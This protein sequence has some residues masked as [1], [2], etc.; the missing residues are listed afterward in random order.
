MPLIFWI[1]TVAMTI[2]ALLFVL[3]PVTSTGSRG[4][5]A[6]LAIAV[7]VTA[8]GLY[9][10]LGSPTLAGTLPNSEQ[11]AAV[12]GPRAATSQPVGSV[13]SLVGGLEER[14]AQNPDDGKGWL[15]LAQSYRHLQR[16]DDALNAY[17]HA[18]RL[19]QFDE[20]LDAMSNG[21]SESA[22]EA[23][24]AAGIS[25]TIS[26]SDEAA[27]RVQPGDRLFIFARASG[28]S[29]A[30]A[31]VVQMPADS[32]PVEYRLSDAD[33]MV[34]GVALSGLDEVVVTARVT[35]A[36]DAK[37]ALQGLEAKSPPVV[38]GDGATVNL[39]IE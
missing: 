6:T 39:T 26:L 9:L 23:R 37:N 12:S 17:A 20:A 29:G 33:S 10:S 22:V 18:V 25:G 38:M 30:P 34:A 16:R 21:G 31:A 7:P 4:L 11:Q 36:G 28:Q 8:A 24:P 32:W 5:V 1:A 27:A 19:G 14:L 2:A 13:A 3:R 35:R 15:L